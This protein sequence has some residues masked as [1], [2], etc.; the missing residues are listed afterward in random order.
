MSSANAPLW[1]VTSYY[2]P[3]GCR[4]R[5]TNFDIF[6]A[7][8]AAPLVAVELSHNGAFELA[9]GDADILVQLH[10]ADVMWQ[11]ER[12]LNVG[13]AAVPQDVKQIARLDCDLIFENDDWMA[14][15]VQAL[16]GANLVHLF[17]RRLNLSREADPESTGDLRADV[18]LSAF[19]ASPSG[20]PS[21]QEL[22]DSDAP[23]TLKRTV[24][25][26][27]AA[28]R[29]ILDRHGLY[30]AA[31]LGSGDRLIL[32]AAFGRCGLGRRT[33]AMNDAQMEHYV[34]WAE[35][36]SHSVRGRVGF[37]EHTVRH[38]WHGDLRDRRYA[39]RHQALARFNFDPAADLALDASG[40]WRWASDKPRLQRYVRDYF[41]SRREDG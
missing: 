9:P 35:P 40:A 34:A 15:A 3:A 17:R 24:G 41:E 23:V 31:I 13:F 10:C 11:K 36:F 14:D 12:L 30:A 20:P 32:S 6:R 8:L 38:L 7:K 39:E 25:L 18:A 5:K 37:I 2:N 1:A 29:E 19:A 33:I 4:R 27:W 22:A 21:D 16:S 26:A 28:R